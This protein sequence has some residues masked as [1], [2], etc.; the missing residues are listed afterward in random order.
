MTGLV[1]FLVTTPLFVT[2]FLFV[3]SFVLFLKSYIRYSNFLTGCYFFV[4]GFLFFRFSY[5]DVFF[6]IDNYTILIDLCLI[7]LLSIL[8]YFIRKE[9]D[10][11]NTDLFHLLPLFFV[12]I[13]FLFYSVLSY[14]LL[15]SFLLMFPVLKWICLVSLVVIYGLYL[16]YSNFLLFIDG[17]VLSHRQFFHFFFMGIHIT[18]PILAVALVWLH[19]YF[20]IIY[21][22]F[23]FLMVFL[24][25]F[26]LV[27]NYF[28]VMFCGISEL[29]SKSYKK[30]HL[31]NVNLDLIEKELDVLMLQNKVYKDPLLSLK[32]LAEMLKVSSHQLSEY[33]NSVKQKSFSQYLMTFRVEEAKELLLKYDWRTTLSIG[34]ECGFN[35]HSSFGRCFKLITGM[36]P[37][38]YR[39]ENSCD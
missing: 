10:F 37:G 29:D 9:S 33:L 24:L 18:L 23:I 36:S 6:L 26:D 7:W 39:S 38:S 22:F 14:P 19:F 5:Y 30:T 16:R 20:F 12:L 31:S 21:N 2:G 11:V 4:F 1:D 32:L 34:V 27:F 3:F 28:Q 13:I 8:F 35:S 25:L 17:S 15:V